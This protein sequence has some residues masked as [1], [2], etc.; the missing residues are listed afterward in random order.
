MY[1]AH[2]RMTREIVEAY[3]I[4]KLEERCMSKPLVSISEKEI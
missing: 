4:G 1:S 3:E 2:S